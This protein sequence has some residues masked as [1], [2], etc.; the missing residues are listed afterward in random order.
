MERTVYIVQH[1]SILVKSMYIL[2]HTVYVCVLTSGKE[3][4]LTFYTSLCS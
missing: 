4:V 2:K 1:R 3:E